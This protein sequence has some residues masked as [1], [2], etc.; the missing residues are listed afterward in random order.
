[1]L[2]KQNICQTL[3]VTKDQKKYYLH[4]NSY[5]IISPFSQFLYMLQYI[6]PRHLNFQRQF[7]TFK[8]TGIEVQLS[9]HNSSSQ[10]EIIA[11]W[12]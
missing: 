2:N 6:R 5:T 4:I 8:E 12:F 7:T 10:L 1:M 3:K 9:D 11:S